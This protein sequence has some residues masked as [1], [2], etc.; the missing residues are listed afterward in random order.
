[1][2]NPWGVWVRQHEGSVRIKQ[3]C[4][5]YYMRHWLR[6]LWHSQSCCHTLC[7]SPCCILEASIITSTVIN[8]TNMS[9]PQKNIINIQ[10]PYNTNQPTE[11]DLW[12]GNFQTISLYSLLEHFLSDS[13]Y[14]KKSF[15][16]IAKYIGNKNID[17]NKSND[18]IEL[19]G[20]GK[21]AWMFLSA[22]YNLGQDLLFA[23]KNKNSFRQNVSH[24][25]TP[26]TNSIIIRKKGE[27]NMD[28]LVSIE[29]LSPPIL[30]KSLK[31]VKE[32]LKF[33]KTS[34]LALNNKS[35]KIVCSSISANH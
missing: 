22:F 23:N 32:I 13:K 12:D 21:A 6:P 11:K 15:T 28:K 18:I 19:K 14:I 16:C 26:K 4:S 5:T 7:P 20:I 17:I 2:Y 29:R 3:G 1:M 30:A 9:L 25:F 33:F 31:E 27:K 35:E 8:N 24:K 10:L 34:K